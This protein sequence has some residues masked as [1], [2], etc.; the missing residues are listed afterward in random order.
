M[1]KESKTLSTD[2]A[3]W[4][5][6]FCITNDVMRDKKNHFKIARMSYLS[7]ADFVT[8]VKLQAKA[9]R[10]CSGDPST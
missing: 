7:A 1:S 9:V 5:C 4:E 10:L 2:Y 6:E 8:G 3:P